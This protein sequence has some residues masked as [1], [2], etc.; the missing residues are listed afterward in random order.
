MWLDHCNYLWKSTII[1]ILNCLAYLTVFTSLSTTSWTVWSI[2]YTGL[3]LC[4]TRKSLLL[5]TPAQCS[6][7]QC[8]C[9]CISNLTYW[10]HGWA[11]IPDIQLS[12]FLIPLRTGHSQMVNDGLWAGVTVAYGQE[13]VTFNPGEKSKLQWA[14]ILLLFLVPKLN[15]VS[16][17][18]EIR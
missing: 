2:V 15:P 9:N 10:I 7:I 17:I 8:V 18:K 5:L 3:L 11:T 12:L 6:D 13:S 1:P 4:L 14:Y 16:N